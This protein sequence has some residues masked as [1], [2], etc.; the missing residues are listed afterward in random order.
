MS[1]QAQPVSDKNTSYTPRQREDSPAL[2]AHQSEQAIR[3]LK[4]FALACIAKL[5][6]DNGDVQPANHEQNYLWEHYLPLKSAA[7]WEQQL[8]RYLWSPNVEDLV[9]IELFNRLELNTI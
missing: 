6:F 5:I 8:R 7:N 1:D 3:S 4:G 9:L 2:S